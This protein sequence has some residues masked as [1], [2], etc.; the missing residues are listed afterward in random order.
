MVD[1][2]LTYDNILRAA[3]N[4]KNI[5]RSP[6]IRFS[7]LA[8]EPIPNFKES[9]SRK[10][11]VHKKLL[12]RLGYFQKPA[13]YEI[14]DSVVSQGQKIIVAHPSFKAYFEAIGV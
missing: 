13:I 3:E 4:I 5:P 7:M 9:K 1:T 12:K 8:T 11:R 14:Q 6:I 10:P 2:T